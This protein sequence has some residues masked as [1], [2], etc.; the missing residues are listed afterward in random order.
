MGRV[1]LSRRAEKRRSDAGREWH[2]AHARRGIPGLGLGLGLG[3]GFRFRVRVGSKAGA[4][5][6]IG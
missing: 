2:A 6:R 5:A 3:L 1:E 4:R